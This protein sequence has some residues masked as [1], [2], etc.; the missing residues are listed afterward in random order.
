MTVL[1]AEHAFSRLTLGGRMFQAEGRMGHGC[2]GR[3]WLG[4][5][6]SERFVWS[7][8]MNWWEEVTM[9][10]LA[11]AGTIQAQEAVSGTNRQERLTEVPWRIF[12]AFP[13]V[14]DSLLMLS[15]S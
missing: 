11:E 12:T 13:T 8:R 9:E 2:E 7:W 10:S 6:R 15:S 14:Y 1:K 4:D 3:H 5:G